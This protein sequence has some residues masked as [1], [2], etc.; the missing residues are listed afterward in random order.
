MVNRGTVQIYCPPGGNSTE[1]VPQLVDPGA[2]CESAAAA[3][4]PR[5][6]AEPQP[7]VLLTDTP[8]ASWTGNTVPGGFG[9]VRWAGAAILKFF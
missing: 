7:P 6:A 9:P 4:L 8:C 5:P 2:E 3:P 1:V